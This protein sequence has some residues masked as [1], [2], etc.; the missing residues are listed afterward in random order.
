MRTTDRQRLEKLEFIMAKS[1][2]QLLA[3]VAL[4]VACLRPTSAIETVDDLVVS[5]YLG[6][7][8]QVSQI[9]NRGNSHDGPVCALS[10]YCCKRSN[11]SLMQEKSLLT[12]LALGELVEPKTAVPHFECGSILI[13]VGLRYIITF[14][15]S[16][17]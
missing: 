13:L 17:C 10:I 15:L 7:W 1:L 3:S 9:G 11:P 16:P 12:T 8:Y 4:G 14:S 2:L 6:R 5:K